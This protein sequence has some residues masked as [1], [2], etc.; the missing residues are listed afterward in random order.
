MSFIPVDKD[1]DFSIH[2][3]PFGVFSTLETPYKRC[4]VAI[5]DFILDL[6]VLEEAGILSDDLDCPP[7]DN[8]V[9]YAESL[10]PFMGLTRAHWRATREKLQSLLSVDSKDD[11]LRANP[12]LRSKALV[13]MSAAIMHLPADIGDYTD[14]YS[15][16]E[17]ATNVGK[18]SKQSVL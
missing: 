18:F 4:G 13:P 17:H 16:R 7:F 2:N 10:K 1:S 12:Q 5:G 8:S 6:R 15:S 11:R 14:F 9:F 3:I